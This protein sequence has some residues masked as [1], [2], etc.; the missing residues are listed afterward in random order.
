MRDVTILSRSDPK[1]DYNITQ[2][3]KSYAYVIFAIMSWYTLYSLKMD[4]SR[5]LMLQVELLI[6]PGLI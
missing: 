3:L 1:Y 4:R 6:K 5:N 2:V